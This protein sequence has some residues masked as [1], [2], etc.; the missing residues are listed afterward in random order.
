[1]FNYPGEHLEKDQQYYKFCLYGFLKNLRFF[2]AFFILFLVEK[3][4]SFTQIGI[5][6]AAREIASNMLEIPSGI[7]ADS[8]GRK[9]TLA[10]SFLVYI[11][12]FSLFYF[13]SHFWIYLAA[14]ILFG[15]GEAFRSGTHKGM[16]MDY[17]KIRGF[18]KQ[19]ANY[20]GH[21]RSWSQ[22]GSALSALLAGVI[23]FSGGDYQIIFLYSIIPYVI[24]FILIISY[25]GTLN[26]SIKTKTDKI[27]SRIGV[28][29]RMLIVNLKQK[30]LRRT[31]YSSA[32]HSAYLRAIKDYI[33]LV[34]LNLALII[35]LLDRVDPK[36]KSG[37]IIGVL[38]FLIFLATSLAS[39][40]SSR[41]AEKIPGNIILLSLVLGF[42]AGAI[43]GI[44]YHFSIWVISLLAFAG[45]YLLE[46][47]RKPILTGAV[48]RQVP[49][50]ILS[51]VL[52]TQSQLKTVFT[53]ILAV[54][55]GVIADRSGIG[56]SLLAV[57]GI[58]LLFTAI[59]ELSARKPS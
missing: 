3:G 58:L 26:H 18:E 5:L 50:E 52:S 20:Y 22:K 28:S 6:Y 48:A 25:P 17:L 2:D 30:Q 31:L 51:S 36:Q 45:I 44:S 1:M 46:N 59:V 40:Y 47:L 49:T 34:M 9:T 43:S 27:R 14:F 4:I 57:S 23:V 13:F 12:S 24:N 7:L 16:I 37:L 42:T 39:K 32:A 11:C 21:T 8:F 38:Y 53:S 41:V 29:I 19:F 10:G 15:I 33:Q 35:P 56:I 55:F 54:A